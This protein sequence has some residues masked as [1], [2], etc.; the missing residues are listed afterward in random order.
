MRYVCVLPGEHEDD[1]SAPFFYGMQAV[2]PVQRVDHFFVCQHFFSE[3]PRYRQ[4]LTSPATIEVFKSYRCV[5][6]TLGI[7]VHFSSERR[8]GHVCVPG[9]DARHLVVCTHTILLG[10]SEVKGTSHDRTSASTPTFTHLAAFPFP[11]QS[12]LP[13]R[14]RVRPE[15][16]RSGLSFRMGRWHPRA[17]QAPKARAVAA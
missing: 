10:R 9:P 13:E 6:Q 15:I 16:V 4:I 1:M 17:P 8:R 2:R 14:P 3:R 11:R 7:D 12:R 5:G